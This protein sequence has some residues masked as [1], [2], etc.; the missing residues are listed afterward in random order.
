MSNMH[1]WSSFVK[2]AK[3]EKCISSSI[4]A[5]LGDV[6]QDGLSQFQQEICGSKIF[7]D[8]SCS[9][10]SSF[11][12]LV[13]RKLR[14]VMPLRSG[15]LFHGICQIGTTSTGWCVRPARTSSSCSFSSRWM[16]DWASARSG[17]VNV[18]CL[19][20]CSPAIC[21]GAFRCCRNNAHSH[22]TARQSLF[23]GCDLC[24]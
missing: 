14:N 12:L 8:Y 17:D 9:G 7:N 15:W 11:S 18:S 6:V 13:R 24:V 23:Q 16:S 10:L 22:V 4:R 1:L 19:H 21:R 2:Y 20:R 5:R 3:S